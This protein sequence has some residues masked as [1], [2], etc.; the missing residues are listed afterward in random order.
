MTSIH[1]IKMREVTDTPVLLFECKLSTAR[2]N[3]GARTR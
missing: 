3:D 1:E 2:W